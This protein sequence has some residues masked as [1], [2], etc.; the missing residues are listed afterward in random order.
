MLTCRELVELVTDYLDGAL[1]PAEQDRFEE[2]LQ[3]CLGC[4]RYLEQIREAMRLAARVGYGAS[5]SRSASQ[6]LWRLRS[7]P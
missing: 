7:S 6:A 1:S 3:R 4:D 2:H 5:S